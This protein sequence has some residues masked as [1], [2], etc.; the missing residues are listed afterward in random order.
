MQVYIMRIFKINKDFCA[1]FPKLC[2]YLILLS[3]LQPQ[4]F[5]R[6]LLDCSCLTPFKNHYFIHGSNLGLYSH[7]KELLWYFAYIFRADI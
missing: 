2:D 3:H 5:D 1:Y 4:N 6:I 7:N